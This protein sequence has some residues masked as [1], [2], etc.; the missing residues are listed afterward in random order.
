[1]VTENISFVVSEKPRCQTLVFI[2]QHRQ[3]QRC[4]AELGF[5][6]IISDNAS[7]KRMIANMLCLPTFCNS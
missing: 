1:M 2:A 3:R 7:N 4:K 6:N 5:V